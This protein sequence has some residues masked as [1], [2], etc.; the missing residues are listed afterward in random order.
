MS[1]RH[2]RSW[3]PRGTHCGA[4]L[5]T[6]S[7][8]EGQLPSFEGADPH[9]R[10]HSSSPTASAE[11]LPSNDTQFKLS[12]ESSPFANV[13]WG[14]FHICFVQM[15]FGKVLLVTRTHAPCP[16]RDWMSSTAYPS[17]PSPT[18]SCS[19]PAAS[20]TQ[21]QHL[22]SSTAHAGGAQN[23]SSASPRPAVRLHLHFSL[24]LADG[25]GS[26]PPFCRFVLLLSQ[27]KYRRYHD[28]CSLGMLQVDV[29]T[30]RSRWTRA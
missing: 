8:P 26:F 6:Q 4:L 10:L 5:S 30:R 13:A 1:A 24:R 20:L 22:G 16:S 21:F 28:A 9:S 19:A 27:R 3:K 23:A 18:V 15:P 11:G 7:S 14:P 25:I 29:Y 17:R 12:N 2:T